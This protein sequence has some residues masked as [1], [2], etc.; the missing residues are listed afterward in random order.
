VFES[1]RARCE[2][3]EGAPLGFVTTV[4]ACRSVRWRSSI[5][6]TWSSSLAG[7]IG[8]SVGYRPATNP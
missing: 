8:Y 5:A 3:L 4:R 1:P 7:R 2:R 6:Y